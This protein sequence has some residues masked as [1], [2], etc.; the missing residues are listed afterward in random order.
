MNCYHLLVSVILNQN[1]TGSILITSASKIL[2]GC[3]EAAKLLE[4][5]LNE[6]VSGALDK[7][8]Q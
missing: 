1:H 2:Q 8:C 5:N 7:N 6:E 3:R 4:T